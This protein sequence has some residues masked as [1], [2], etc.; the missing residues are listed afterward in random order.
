VALT[1]APVLL[2]TALLA[3]SVVE[4]RLLIEGC[5]VLFVVIAVKTKTELG[6]VAQD[7]GTAPP[8]LLPVAEP[9]RR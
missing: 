8:R 3:Q 6:A 9:A 2:L 5:W 1:L 4:S 7:L